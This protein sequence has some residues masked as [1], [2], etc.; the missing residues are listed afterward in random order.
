MK[1]ILVL[2]TALFIA[3]LMMAY[4]YFKGLNAD[5]R[6]SDGSLY[7]ATLNSGMVLSFENDKSIIDML[8]GQGIFQ[9][10]TTEDRYAEMESLKAYLVGNPAVNKLIAKQAIYISLI[11]DDDKGIDFLYSCQ[12][13]ATIS[14]AQLLSAIKQNSLSLITKQNYSEIVLP[15]SNTFYLGVK[16]RVVLLSA[17]L[18]PIK[19][20]LKAELKSNA[21]TEYIK[22]NSRIRKNSLA[23]L[24]INFE[25]LPRLMGSIT[26]GK[27]TGELEVF[28]S[29][30]GFASFNYNFSKE[31]MLL[32]G[33]TSIEDH[34]Y[35]KTFAEQHPQKISITNI[36]PINTANYCLFAFDDYASWK[37]QLKNWFLEQ[38]TTLERKES[39]AKYNQQYR[40]D[41]EKTIPQ[42]IANQFLTFQLSTSEK[43]GAISLSNG[44]KLQQLLLDLSSDYSPDISLMKDDKLLYYLFGEPFKNFKRPYYCIIDNYMVFANHASTIQSFLNNYRNNRLLISDQEYGDALNQ[45][46]STANV[47]YYISFKN[48]ADIFVKN[49]YLPYYKQLRSEKGMRDY[50]AFIYQLSADKGKFQSNILLSKKANLVLEDS[51]LV[52]VDST[53]SVQKTEN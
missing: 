10:I 40:I 43:L 48:S 29:L 4:L 36:L 12:L 24:Y 23:E 53:T 37:N 32:S 11:P 31:K 30:Q 3:I 41:L 13:N 14:T 47:S 35:H 33:S 25:K 45:L 27:L 46:S 1:K 17:K 5:Q 16:D 28:N 2:T 20:I 6:N 50:T 44:E 49:L 8:S 42:Y 34:N 51:S 52:K 21:F 39:F 26:P 19:E 22:S 15:D 18:N 38:K 7:A 9:E